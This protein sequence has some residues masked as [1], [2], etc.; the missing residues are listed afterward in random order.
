M[1]QP[2][3]TVCKPGFAYGYQPNSWEIDDLMR[4]ATEV[5]N[6]TNFLRMRALRAKRR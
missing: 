1:Q 2:E 4:K 6:E 5:V 3:V